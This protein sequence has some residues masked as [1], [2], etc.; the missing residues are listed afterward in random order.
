MNLGQCFRFIRKEEL[1]MSEG[2]L[3]D[4]YLAVRCDIDVVYYTWAARDHAQD[5]VANTTAMGLL[6]GGHCVG[7]SNPG[8][9]KM[10]HSL[11]H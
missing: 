3:V 9:G 8:G 10:F 1:E 5:V 11:T 4:D 7:A 6:C 2:Y